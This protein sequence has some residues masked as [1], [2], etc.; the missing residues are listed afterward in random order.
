[1][2]YGARRIALRA[3]LPKR[4]PPKI[5]SFEESVRDMVPTA[6]WSYPTTIRFG[7]GRITELPEACAAAGIKRPLLVTDKGL[8]TLP[9]TKRAL[10]IMEQANL[11]RGL[12]HDVDPNPNEKNLAGGIA[13][14]K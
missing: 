7:A 9:V 8:S 4:D 13:A 12:F 5:V 10:D 11:G 1:Q 14:Y 2:G 3:R 6:N